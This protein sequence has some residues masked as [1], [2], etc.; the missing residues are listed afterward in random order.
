MAEKHGDPSKGGRVRAKRLT[1]EE[2][3]QIAREAAAARWE[4]QGKGK[5]HHAT[6]EG[7]LAVGDLEI[8]CAVL[9]DGTRVLSETGIVNSLGLYRSGAVLV[10]SQG[11]DGQR[12]PLFVAN[13]NIVPFIEDD[14]VELLTT[15]TWYFPVGGGTRNRGTDATLLP[16]VCDVWLRARDAGVLSGNKRQ[17]QV[18]VKADILMRGLAETGVVALVDEATG[19]QYER[20][21]DALAKI[22]EAFVSKELR[23][24]VK[25]FDPE[26]YEG[27]CRLWDVPYPPQKNQ[28]PQYFGTLTNNFVYDRLAPGV[29]RAIQKKNP[30]QEDG[31]RKNKNHQYLTEH[32][33]H[34]ALKEHLSAVV[35]LM[36]VASD[37]DAFIEMLDKAKPKFEPMPL[38]DGDQ[39]S[40]D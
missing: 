27:L 1:K 31:R 30:V 20:D 5:V 12:L 29:K 8:P 32:K 25:T 15:P 28:F 35:A 37:K 10:R 14:L 4:K 24:W 36:K 17:E 11:E 18:A 19:Y 7:M 2:R 26:Y 6:H 34:P 33:G 39:D 3:S 38:F 40:D 9:E 21:R 13:K 16:K 22:L 23:K